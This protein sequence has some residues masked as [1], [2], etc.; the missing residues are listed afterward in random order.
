MLAS[1]QLDHT[2]FGFWN[3]MCL[4]VMVPPSTLLPTFTI[5][6]DYIHTHRYKHTHK[7]VDI[8]WSK[9]P[10]IKKWLD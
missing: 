4:W 8:N 3:I 7:G 10:K 2:P 5:P 6:L 1:C 9:S